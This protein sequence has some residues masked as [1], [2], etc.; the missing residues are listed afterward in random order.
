MA[1]KVSGN[2]VDVL[3]G[4]IY[5]GSV[6][7]TGEGITRIARDRETYHS[8]VLPGFIDAHI[9]IESTMLVPSE[10]ARAAL[11]HGTLAVISDPHEIA[12]V[13]GVDGVDFMIANG[14]TVPLRFFFGAPSCVPATPFETAGAALGVREVGSLLARDEIQ[15]LSEVMNYPGVLAGDR[16]LMEKIRAARERGKRVDG[17]APGLT[18]SALHR[19]IGAGITTDHESL[20]RGEAEEKLRRG[21][22]ILIREG[23][24][25]RVFD[26]FMT[27]LE[28]H[29]HQ[30][31]FCSDDLHAD[32]LLAGHIDRLV[33]RAVAAG[34]DVMKVLRAASVNPVMHYGLP[35][36]LLRVNDPADFIVVNNLRDF[37]VEKVVARGITAAQHGV[38]SFDSPLVTRVNI[39]KALEKK[40]EDFAVPVEGRLMEV[41]HVFDGQLVTGRITVPPSV[42]AGLAV[43]DRGQDILKIAVINRYREE[44]PS[45]AFVHGF[46][47]REGALASSVA[48]DS[49]NIVA[50][51]V[52]DEDLCRAVNLV[53]RHRGG[54]AA[55]SRTVEEVLP[56]PVA[57]IMSDQGAEEVAQG[58]RRLNRQAKALGC[59]LTAPFMTLSFMALP[60]IPRLKLTDKGLFDAETFSFTGLFR[61]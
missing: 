32:D 35:V 27:L 12:N 24:A 59:S 9:H 16:E 46:G 53:I 39:F 26:A 10:F 4:V 61:P 49:H 18:G 29:P 58:Y 57:G 25:A 6:E 3:G 31:M 13:L 34:L 14:K 40:P 8:F 20:T 55:V 42:Q 44:G 37:V 41:I 47:L 45:V 54:I 33:R 50:V 30:I 2:I 5:P 48:H 11:P 52:R 28:T 60:V 17:H 19:Y 38:P 51:G 23:S 22:A 36:G 56:L 15:Y 1:D 7:W 43:S 21:M